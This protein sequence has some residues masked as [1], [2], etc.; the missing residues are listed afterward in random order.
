MTS[1]T[2]KVLD[3]LNGAIVASV[4]FVEFNTEP[5]TAGEARL[6]AE[7]DPPAVLGSAQCCHHHQIADVQLL[8]AKLVR[9]DRSRVW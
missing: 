2:L 6:A 9:L 3:T 5:N 1:G 8:R 7:S 4:G